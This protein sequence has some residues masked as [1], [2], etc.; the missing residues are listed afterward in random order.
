MKKRLIIRLIIDA[1]ISLNVV[2]C[3]LYGLIKITDDPINPTGVVLFRYF[4]ILSNLYLAIIFGIDIIY[5]IKKLKNDEYEIPN[6][7]Y[8]LRIN[9]VSTV[10][11][12]L[13]TVFFFLS[14][15]IPLGYLLKGSNL[16]LHL[17]NP[18]VSFIG[19]LLLDLKNYS[20]KYYLFTYIPFVAYGIL[21][22]I[23]VVALKSWPDFYG[24]NSHNFKDLW[25]VS[26]FVMLGFVFLIILFMY[27]MNKLVIKIREK[28]N[29]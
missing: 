3:I 17:I 2:I 27:L 12:T 29:A 14:F 23:M 20:F 13:F 9:S 4:T 25:Y 16:F 7:I 26:T 5:V 24:F 1:F 8:L 19:I 6:L 21:Y 11:I 28:K 18:L 10:L 15:I 22:L